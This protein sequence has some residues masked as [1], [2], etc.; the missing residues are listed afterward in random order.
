MGKLKDPLYK[1]ALLRS[2]EFEHQSDLNLVLFHRDELERIEAG[3]RVTAC[4]NDSITKRLHEFGIFEK[5]KI[6]R[7]HRIRLTDKAKALLYPE[8]G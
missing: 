5:K 2:D 6:G 7:T 8:R 4:L 3:E 1:E